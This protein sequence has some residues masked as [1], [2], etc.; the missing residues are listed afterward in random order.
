MFSPS[1]IN[2]FPTFSKPENLVFYKNVDSNYSFKSDYSLMYENSSTILTPTSPE[3]FFSTESELQQ[4]LNTDNNQF[5]IIDETEINFE[6]QSI[7]DTPNSIISSDT[8]IPDK[9]LY[10]KDYFIFEPEYIEQFQ[11]LYQNQNEFD[12]QLE[13]EYVNYD[14]VNN[15]SKYICDTLNMDPWMSPKLENIQ[16]SHEQMV[17]VL[18]PINTI[19]SFQSNDLNDTDYKTNVSVDDSYCNEID[20]KFDEEL[21]NNVDYNNDENAQEKPNRE[22]KCLYLSTEN[23]LPTFESLQSPKIC[24]H[25]ENCNIDNTNKQ[26]REIVLQCMWENCYRIFDDQSSLVSHIEKTHVD[27]KKIDGFSCHWLH[28]MRNKK[29]FNARYKLLIHMRVHSGEKPNK[30]VVSKF[31]C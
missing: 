15:Q 24:N 28:C 13:N 12:D 1:E 9:H 19:S 30:C 26:V 7:V 20:N 5:N 17:N 31:L 21:I 25:I 8:P 4:V 2:N 18:P 27:V 6:Y 14:E 16:Y 22:Y 3:T 23:D 10:K 11:S 29:P